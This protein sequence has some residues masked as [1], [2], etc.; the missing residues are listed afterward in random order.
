MSG[1]HDHSNPHAHTHD[2]R[3]GPSGGR[4]SD[5]DG[6]EHAGFEIASFP[7]AAPAPAEYLSAVV[8]LLAEKGI[9]AVDEIRKRRQ[10]IR[11]RGPRLGA[12]VVARAWVDDAF[13][14]RLLSDAVAA[15]RELGIEPLT[16]SQGELVALENTDEL[17]HAIVCTLCSCYPT[18]LLGP[19]PEWYRSEEYRRRIVAEPR[20]VL[21]EF[22]LDLPAG[23]RIRVVDSTTECRYLV[24]PRRPQGS[25]G[26][27]I[28]ELEALVTDRSMVGTAEALAP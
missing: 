23:M 15:V 2:G 3:T 25:E 4:S 14:Q 28:D 17:H 13:R 24:I 10:E 18:A 12:R 8:E 5:V 27:G 22:G 11:A 19:A 7:T 6:S 20:D 21:R 26:L 16:P 9:I 1:D